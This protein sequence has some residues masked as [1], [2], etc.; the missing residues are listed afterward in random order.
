MD[1]Q[2]EYKFVDENA[3]T[4]LG[5][6]E[7]VEMWGDEKYLS[8]DGVINVSKTRWETAQKYERSEW[9]QR[10]FMADDDRNVFHENMFN[11]YDSLDD[12]NV[13]SFIELGCGPFTNARIILEK[14]PN[15]KGVTL[16][17][18][19]VKDYLSHTNCKYKNS[20]LTL[21]NQRKVEAN[22]VASSI[23]EYQVDKTFDMVVMINV[24]EHCFDIPKIFENIDAMLNKGGV[25]VYADVQ[26]DIESAKKLVKF[27]YNA[28]HPIRP[29]VEYISG[30]LD[31]KFEQIFSKTF[32]EDLG[33]VMAE[34][35]YFIGK[36]I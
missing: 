34:E 23:E 10:A 35:R 5:L 22:L 24:L 30:I 21:R 8:D 12:V 2:I 32:D 16:L 33:G 3:M 17:D 36:K 26:F 11:N 1:E 14:F 15:L 31:T 9:M 13:E 4:F 7:L 20:Q 29:T 6:K 25:L 18:P 28:G 19:L 27:K